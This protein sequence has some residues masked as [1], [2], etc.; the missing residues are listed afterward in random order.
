MYTATFSDSNCAQFIDPL[1]RKESQM[2]IHSILCHALY[3]VHLTG[4][5]F[6][7]NK[8]ILESK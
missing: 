3:A 5:M 1:R 4:V 6:H 7:E 2:K 8:V